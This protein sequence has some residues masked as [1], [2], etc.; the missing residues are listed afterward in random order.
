MTVEHRGQEA[1]LAGAVGRHVKKGRGVGSVGMAP[2][3]CQQLAQLVTLVS[4]AGR[5]GD[6]G[7]IKLGACR[8]HRTWSALHWK[9]WQAQGLCT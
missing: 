4:M 1:D 8:L 3:A 5:H 9:T 2:C 7:Q 6:C